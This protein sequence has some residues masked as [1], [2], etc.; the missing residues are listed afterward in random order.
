MVTASTSQV[1][2]GCLMA[3]QWKPIVGYEDLYQVSDQ[4]R[5]RRIARGP[6]THVGLIRRLDNARN[7]YPRVDL[8][9][10]GHAEKRTVHSLVTEA[11][12]GPRPAG[13]EVNHENGNKRDNRVSNLEYLTKSENVKHTYRVLGRKA[14]RGEANGSAKLTDASVRE[15]RRLY[16]EGGVTHCELAK[17]YGVDRATIGQILRLEHWTHVG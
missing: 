4:G 2:Q 13:L 6:H 11:F 16:A 12:L 10:N 15:I 14:P 3:E 5:V 1:E 7:G 8:W 9:R 17:Q